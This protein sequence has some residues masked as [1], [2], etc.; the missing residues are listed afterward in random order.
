MT[1]FAR[2]L[3]LLSLASLARPVRAQNMNYCIDKCWSSCSA[4]PMGSSAKSACVDQCIQYTCRASLDVWGAIAYSKPDK[5]FGYSF[6]LADEATARKVAMENCRKHG[7]NCVVETAFS[8]SCAALAAGGD[9]IGWGTERTREAAEKRALSQCAL[10]GANG[11]AVQTWVCSAPN[12]AA[13]SGTAPRP[14]PPPALRA[15]AWGAIAYS[16]ADMGAGWSQGKTDRTAA[17]R[18][19]MALCQQRGKSCVLRAT[20]NKQCGALAADRNF[21]GSATAADAREAQQKAMDECR[22]AGGT[23]CALHIMF[24]S[25]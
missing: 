11:C 3:I 9:R 7:S 25:M 4:E 12:A 6:E 24:C 23:H 20:F 1:H 13:N 22:K 18:E 8:R 2:L 21:E 10:T 5:A 16:A 14:S 17:E 19:A 15:V